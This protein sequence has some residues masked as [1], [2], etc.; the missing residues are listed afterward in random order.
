M[1]LPVGHVIKL[2]K[3]LYEEFDHVTTDIYIL[4]DTLKWYLITTGIK[5]VWIRNPSYTIN[6]EMDLIL[7]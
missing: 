4:I 2:P 6:Q 3:G 1:Y 5:P 7:T